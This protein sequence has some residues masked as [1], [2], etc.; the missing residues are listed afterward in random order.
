MLGLVGATPPE[1]AWIV[2]GRIATAYY[3]IHFIILLPFVGWLERPR[4][5]PGSIAE[6]VLGPDGTAAAE[7]AAQPGE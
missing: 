7:P 3:F 5:L 2:F 1:G 4:A 6:P